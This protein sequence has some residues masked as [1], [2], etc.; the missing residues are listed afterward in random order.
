MVP[1]YF[2]YYWLYISVEGFLDFL[3]RN[4]AGSL[5]VVFLIGCVLTYIALGQESSNNCGIQ[6]SGDGST[7]SQ[8]IVVDLSGAVTNPG[9]YKIESDLRVGEIIERAGGFSEGASVLWITKNLNLAQKITDTQKIYVPFE[10]ETT[11]VARYDISTLSYSGSNG[12]SATTSSSDSSGGGEKVSVNSAG[13][14]DLDA[15]PGIGP[16][17]AQKIVSNR[18]YS[19]IEEFKT[20]SGLSESTIEKIEDLISF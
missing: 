19:D 10:W 3:K 4:L 18:P 13:V 15:L 12:T 2:P 11:E 16:V 9:L 8:E 7:D 17:Y 1:L 6:V 20:K 5:G 14:E